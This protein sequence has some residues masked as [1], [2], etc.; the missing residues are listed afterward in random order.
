M[1]QRGRMARPLYSAEGRPG[2]A[3]AEDPVNRRPH[4]RTE[5]AE[6]TLPG[7]LALLAAAFGLVAGLAT[8]VV[9]AA[10][11]AEGPPPAGRVE[12]ARRFMETGELSRAVFHLR[13]HLAEAPDDVDARSLL[14]RSQARLGL[15]RAALEQLSLVLAVRPDDTAALRTLAEL[16]AV[17]GHEDAA[18]A[19]AARLRDA[20]ETGDWLD[21][22]EGRLLFRIGRHEEAA[23]PLGRALEARPGSPS[24][25][26]LAGL[27]ALRRGDEHLAEARDRLERALSLEPADAALHNSLGFVHER[28]GDPEGAYLHYVDAEH[29]S[30]EAVRYAD[31]RRRLEEVLARR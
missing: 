1:A 18:L 3:L 10:R 5:T 25:L 28:L 8:A 20:G 26:K 30:G 15:R 29:V 24:L 14:A 21:E 22:L 16:Q 4:P 6:P 9:A 31:N 12:Q 7:E 27:N 11:P 19:T 13:R 23:G 2:S 17:A